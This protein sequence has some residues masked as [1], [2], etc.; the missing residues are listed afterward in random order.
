M[1]K[2][3]SKTNKAIKEFK[4]FQKEINLIQNESAKNLGQELLKKLQK[5]QGIIDN[6]HSTMSIKDID[7]EKIKENVQLLVEIRKNILKLI[8]DSKS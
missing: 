7:A 5:Q 8:K 3:I 4:K 6:L 1:L 2:P